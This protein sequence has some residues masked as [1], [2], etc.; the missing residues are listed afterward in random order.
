[1]RF[2]KKR[3]DMGE[4]AWDQYQKARNSQKVLRFK[5]RNEKV[6]AERAAE[7]RRKRKRKLVEYK[8]GKCERC[9]YDKDCLRSYEFH[10]IDPKKKDF[11]VAAKS[12]GFEKLKKEVDKCMLVCRNCHA[13]IHDE[14]DK[15]KNNEE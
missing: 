8:G 14:L 10:H 9:G 6:F 15:E 5:S 7:S 3:L 13:E 1:M 12:L 11:T 4:A 2:S